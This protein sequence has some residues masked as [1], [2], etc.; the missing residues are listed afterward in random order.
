MIMKKLSL[1]IVTLILLTGCSSYSYSE[2]DQTKILESQT[3][4]LEYEKCL[5]LEREKWIA[6]FRNTNRDSDWLAW[7]ES[8]LESRKTSVFNFAL[9]DCRKYRPP[10]ASAEEE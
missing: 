2:E 6:V 10:I 1:F 8:E 4:L 3:Q 7:L 9:Q 5:D